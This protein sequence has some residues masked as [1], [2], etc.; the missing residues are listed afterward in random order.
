MYCLRMAQSRCQ[1]GIQLTI[2]AAHWCRVDH[3]AKW[4][5]EITL[6]FSWA[7]NFAIDNL[8]GFRE[9]LG[10]RW[11]GI[12]SG[13]SHAVFI[14]YRNN[15]TALACKIEPMEMISLRFED[16]GYSRHAVRLAAYPR[17]YRAI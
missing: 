16:H 6:L 8:S 9:R 5:V 17:L 2:A 7:L 11:K 14:V 3:A 4:N 1:T 10:R 13:Q 15:E 12:R